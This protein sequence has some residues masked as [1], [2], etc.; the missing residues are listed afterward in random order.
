MPNN[1]YD[2]FSWFPSNFMNSVDDASLPE[3]VSS[4]LNDYHGPVCF[5]ELSSPANRNKTLLRK[6]ERKPT[7]ESLLFSDK[8][9]ENSRSQ[10]SPKKPVRQSTIVEQPST[11][12][13]L[14]SLAPMSVSLV[15]MV[16]TSSSHD[17]GKAPRLPVRQY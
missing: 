6:P 7:L 2:S 8:L 15:P 12:S 3:S 10:M 11:I 5:G 17:G 9:F 4:I 13:E 16:W 14:P 1:F